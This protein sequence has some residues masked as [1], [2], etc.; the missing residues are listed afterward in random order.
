MMP[1]TVSIG[2]PGRRAR[3]SSA[4]D[5]NVLYTFGSPRVTKA[6]RSPASR[7]ATT[8]SAARASAEERAPPSS[9]ITKPIRS[10]D[11]SGATSRTMISARPTEA[12]SV[13]GASTRSAARSSATVRAVT[14]SLIHI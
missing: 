3:T 13:L 12:R 5:E 2:T 6:T 14:L 10:T 9:S 11:T 8:R 7:A 1:G 4:S